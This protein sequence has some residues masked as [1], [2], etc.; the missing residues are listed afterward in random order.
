MIKV[1]ALFILCALLAAPAFAGLAV[2]PGSPVHTH[3]DA[4]TGGGTLTLSNTLSSTK[5]CASGFGRA[6]LNYCSDSTPVVT[7]LTR[8]VC[9]AVA[10]SAVDSLSE[11]LWFNLVLASN[12][13]IADRSILVQFYTDNG[14]TISHD[15]GSFRGAVQFS[16]REFAAVVAATVLYQTNRDGNFPLPSA[17]V[18]TY[19]RFTDDTGNQN[20]VTIGRLGYWD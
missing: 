1:R 20:Q 6:V 3:S 8:D 17:G 11:H 7:A 13:A 16:G 12:N 5:A 4:N 15:A 10:A 19:V 14:C 18:T 9:T 2:T